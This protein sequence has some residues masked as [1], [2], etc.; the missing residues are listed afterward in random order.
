MTSVTIKVL[1]M[2]RIKDARQTAGLSQAKMSA[3][4]EIPKRTIEDW[5]AGRSKPPVYVENLI[6]EKLMSLKERV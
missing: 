5:E 1:K 2:N 6:V 4:L 3:L